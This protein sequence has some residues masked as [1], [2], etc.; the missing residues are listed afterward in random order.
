[1]IQQRELA[2]QSPIAKIKDRPPTDIFKIV[3]YIGLVNL[4]KIFD[5][6]YILFLYFVSSIIMIY[7]LD[8][9]IAKSYPIQHV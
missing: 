7:K 8:A 3:L 1:M 2:L 9:R 4:Y 6:A 5:E